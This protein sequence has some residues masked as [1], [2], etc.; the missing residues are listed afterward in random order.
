[1]L[2]NV[3]YDVSCSFSNS[4]C[5]PGNEPVG[6]SCSPCS[7][8]YFQTSYGRDMCQLCGLGQ[9][10]SSIGSASQDLCC[11][12][13]IAILVLALTSVKWYYSMVFLMFFFLSVCDFGYGYNGSCYEC[14]AGSY[15]DELNNTECKLCVNDDP[16]TINMNTG[17]VSASDCGNLLVLFS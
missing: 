12:Y 7:R 15:S 5:G 2:R 4:V 9:N 6:D 8:G 13:F 14:P 16:N 11:V 1:M 3:L 10:T 17:S